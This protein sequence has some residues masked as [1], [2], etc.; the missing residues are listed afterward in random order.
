MVELTR[1]GGASRPL[2]RPRE[3]EDD[4]FDPVDL[5]VRRRR[6][7]DGPAGRGIEDEPISVN[8]LPVGAASTAAACEDE[9][10]GQVRFGAWDARKGAW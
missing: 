7:V 6:A 5:A 9:G 1:D 2:V 8:L 4:H 10:Y 3:P